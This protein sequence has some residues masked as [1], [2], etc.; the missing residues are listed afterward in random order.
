MA[1]NAVQKAQKRAQAYIV[2]WLHH[3]AKDVRAPTAVLSPAEGHNPVRLCEV[4]MLLVHSR[5]SQVEAT[6]ESD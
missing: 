3:F 1:G 2:P 4:Q 5:A 6:A